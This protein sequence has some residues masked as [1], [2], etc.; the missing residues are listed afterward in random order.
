MPIVLL[1]DA[2]TVGGYPVV[3]VVARAD[4]P[5]VGQ[6]RPGDRV[7]FEVVTID[8]ANRRWRRTESS[9]RL[10]ALRRVAVRFR[11]ATVRKGTVAQKY[12]V[13][14]V[15]Q[16][17]AMPAALSLVSQACHSKAY[18]EAA[19]RGL[20]WVLGENELN[21]DL[22]D[23]QEALVLRGIDQRDDRFEIIRRMRA[24]HPGRCLYALAVSQ[25]ADSRST[26]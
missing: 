10:P 24:Y 9:G 18:D 12:P 1:P 4:R 13:Y 3:A 5:R 17:G 15:H 25:P 26:H 16:D 6:L 8:A 2:Q 14:S 19:H 20:A 21:V 7:G 11:T 22:V 23:D